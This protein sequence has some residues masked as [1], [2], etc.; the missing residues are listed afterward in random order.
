[1]EPKIEF[2]KDGNK[3]KKITTT[4]AVATEEYT[5]AQILKEIEQAE[6]NKVTAAEESVKKTAEAEAYIANLIAQ[7]D[8]V[9]AIKK[10]LLQKAD[11][12]GVDEEPAPEEV[13]K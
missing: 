10:E 2:V 7:A 8:A 3:L 12:L 4:T 11:E 1:M 13:I 5:K 6:A 9:V